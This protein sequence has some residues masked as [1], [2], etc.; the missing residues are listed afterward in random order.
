ML[1][2]FQKNKNRKNNNKNSNSIV[3]NP[4]VP[5]KNVTTPHLCLKQN[6]AKKCVN[7]AKKIFSTTPF[8]L[9]YVKI[10]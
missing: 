2:E 6:K 5:D 8:F 7:L 9:K 4:T 3:N 1:Y 10:R